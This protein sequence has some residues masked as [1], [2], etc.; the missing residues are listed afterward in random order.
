MLLFL[1]ALLLCLSVIVEV[2]LFVTYIKSS[3]GKYPPFIPS[4]G[5]MRRQCLAEAEQYLIQERRPLKIVDLGSGDGRLLLPLA[6]RFPQH[7][8]CGIEWEWALW[9]ISSFR[10]RQKKNIHFLKQNFMTANLSDFDVVLCF[11]SNELSGDLSK[12]LLRELKPGS[13]IISSAFVLKELKPQKTI[14]ARTYGFMPIKVYVYK[15]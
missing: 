13:I 8:F 6:G 4:F 10:A 2:Y 7:S 5:A 12:K 14:S 3:C 11:L 15:I 1:S 9:K